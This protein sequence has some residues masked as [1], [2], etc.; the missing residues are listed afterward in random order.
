MPPGW[1]YVALDSSKLKGH[2]EWMSMIQSEEYHATVNESSETRNEQHLQSSRYHNRKA[3]SDVQS[4]TAFDE[5]ASKHFRPRTS[6][7]ATSGPY[8]CS[9]WSSLSK[10]HSSFRHACRC[11]TVGLSM[12]SPAGNAVS[13]GRIGIVIHQA[14]LRAPASGRNW[15]YGDWGFEQRAGRTASTSG[16]LSQRKARSWWYILKPTSKG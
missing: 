1:A 4:S 9:P 6:L 14:R 15:C 16:R 13:G 2:T 12:S 11:T 3:H 5:N 8:S 7:L 10:L